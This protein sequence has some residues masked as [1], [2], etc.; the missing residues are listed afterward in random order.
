MSNFSVRMRT[1]VNQRRQDGAMQPTV[2]SAAIVAVIMSGLSPATLYAAENG[3]GAV[4]TL[5]VTIITRGK[6]EP[7]TGDAASTSATLAPDRRVTIDGEVEPGKAVATA[8][9]AVD[10]PNGGLIWATEDPTLGD[11]VLNVQGSSLAAFENGRF[12]EPLRF[13]AYSNYAGFIER[14]ELVLYRGGDNDL[15]TP[16]ATQTLESANSTDLDWELELPAGLNL[17]QGD[18]LQ[19]ILRAYAADGSVDET[20]PQRLQLVRPEDR[21]RNL[22]ELRQKADSSMR[23]LS[24]SDLERRRLLQ[25]SYGQGSNL[26]QQNISIYGSRV[27]LFGQDLPEGYQLLINDQSIPVDQE[28]KFVAEYLLPVGSHDF[29][30]SLRKGDQRIS[31]QLNVDVSGQYMFLVAIADVTA[32][33]NRVSGSVEALSA[34]DRYEDFLV[35]GRLGFYLKGK[36]KGKYL[37]TAQADTQEQRTGDL[38]TGFFKADAQDVFRRL[39]PDAY[40]PVYGDDSTT[41]RDV[42]TQGKLYVRVDWDQNQALWG[43][44]Q[45]G[46]TGTEYAQYV[47][48][49]YG[50]AVKWRSKGSTQLGDARTELKVFASEAQT[51]LGHSEFLGTGGSLYYLKHTDV[52]PG[53]DQVVLEMRD[54]TTGRTEA[55]VPLVRDVDYQMDELQGRLILTRPLMQISRENAP[56]L[57]RDTPLGGYQNILLVDYE[58]ISRG[59]SYGDVTAGARGKQWFGEHVALG[60]TYVDEMREADDYKL[61]GVDLTL[62]AGR[63]TY[64]KVEQAR[65]ESAATSVFRSDNGGLSFSRIN[66]LGDREGDAYAAEARAN[67][68]EL[69]YTQREW[70]LGGWYRDVDSGYSISRFD[71]GMPLTEKGAEFSGELTDD[72]LVSGRVSDA[73]RGQDRFEQAQVMGELRLREN[74]RLAAELRQVRETRTGNSVDGTLAALRYTHRLTPSVELYGIGQMTVD[75]DGGYNNND[76]VT[77]GGRYLFGDLS[78]VGGEVTHG[79]RGDALAVD[80][81]YRLASDHTLYAGYTYSTDRTAETDPLFGGNPGGLT[82]GQRWR[83]SNKTS[84]F[85]ESQ[86][87]KAGNE[88][89][90][91]HTF[92]MDFYPIENWNY[93]FTLQ[94]AELDSFNGTVDREAVSVRGGHTSPGT[95]WS[96]ALEWRR[97]TGAER[98]RQW[99]TTNRLMHKL[100]EDW[101]IAGRFNYSDTKDQIDYEQGA[102]FI[103]SNIGFAWRPADSVRW[104]MLGKYTYLYDRSTFEQ[105]Q[106]D[107]WYDQRSHVLA[108]EGTYRFDQHWEFAGKVAERYG[109]ARAGR[110]TG[111][112]FDSRAR[113]TAAQARYRLHGSWSALGE[114]RWLDVRD[115]GTR[116]GWLAGVDRDLGDHFRIGVGY[117]FTDFSDDLTRHD[118]RYRGWY[119]NMVGYY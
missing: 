27:R 92:G 98:R 48:S 9:F 53:S 61:M 34:D 10:L 90:L 73:E 39:D 114:Y 19:Y 116:Q 81:E 49:L 105:D 56:S 93:G 52:L 16:L 12:T 30:L 83:L 20:W 79:A 67:F 40:Y 99:L 112:W 60:A 87:L 72:F 66:P 94:Q 50:A 104:G 47:R 95:S 84:L 43:N 109:E 1:L 70:A 18:E 14:M 15:V 108:L 119:L 101:R 42:D 24:A 100:N 36:V 3:A 80:G 55:R 111:E 13:H 22:E 17:R 63:G 97:D 28:R 35:E 45:T 46:I 5:P 54:P 96:S 113:F 74:D 41:T 78:S 103:E 4:N 38:F 65:T 91:S 115:G 2:L 37:V 85:N 75:K 33:D 44:F 23:D 26:R 77:L 107:A 62:Q 110:A 58:Y 29:D 86:W 59:L 64:L 25:T 21:Q 82:L 68:K 8:R 106:S 7:V 89:G 71:I 6:L 32:S 88:Q 31:E 118:Y 102:R 117:N 76:A 57:T 11:P 51:G 69:G